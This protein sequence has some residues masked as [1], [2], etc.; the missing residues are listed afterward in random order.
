MNLSRRTFSALLAGT[1]FAAAFNP[2]HGPTPPTALGSFGSIGGVT[3]AAAQQYTKEAANPVA[4]PLMTQWE[5]AR[6]VLGDPS[7]R[8]EFISRAYEENR[9]IYQ[10]DPDIMIRRSWSPMAKVTFQRQRNVDQA[11]RSVL[12][13]PVWSFRDKVE[14]LIRRT[15]WG[16]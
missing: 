13:Q 15:I 16:I 14:Q 12:E 1:P 10:I 3:G 11:L 9:H 8:R 2:T 5:A 7:L 4:E 6:K